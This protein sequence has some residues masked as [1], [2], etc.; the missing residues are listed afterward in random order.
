MSSTNIANYT[1]VCLSFGLIHVGIGCADL[2]SRHGK[3]RLQAIALVLPILRSCIALIAI[4]RVPQNRQGT[5][6]VEVDDG[7]KHQEITESTKHLLAA[8][9]VS[10]HHREWHAVAA[11]GERC[12]IRYDL[13]RSRFDSCR[14]WRGQVSCR[15]FGHARMGE[16]QPEVHHGFGQR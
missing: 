5:W 16:G 10:T 6:A 15:R 12:A 1:P 14:T 11:F 8:H 9:L 2:Q 7:Q 13:D 4:P 3:A